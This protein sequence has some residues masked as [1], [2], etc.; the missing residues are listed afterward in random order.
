MNSP[1]NT[2]RARFL[3]FVR[4][5]HPC[6]SPGPKPCP[7]F[8]IPTNKIDSIDDQMLKLVSKRAAIAREVGHLRCGAAVSPRA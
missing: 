6:L 4:V 8:R 3:S 2:V 1:T 7:T 5:R